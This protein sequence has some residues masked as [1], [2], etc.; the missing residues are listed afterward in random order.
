MKYLDKDLS[1]HLRIMTCRDNFPVIMFT[2]AFPA[3]STTKT[4]EANHKSFQAS[5]C[6][7]QNQTTKFVKLTL[8]T[9]AQDD[10]IMHNHS[11][12]FFI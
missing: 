7:Y 11:I 3:K 5:R 10:D 2:V 12:A 1:V 4:N 8:C 9:L 6:I